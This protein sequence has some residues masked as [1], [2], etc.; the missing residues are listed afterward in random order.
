MKF[1]GERYVPGTSGQI[2]LEHMQRYALCRELARGQRVLDIACGEGY[3]AA[4]LAASAAHTVGIDISPG[5]I[6]HART[7]YRIPKLSFAVGAC[8]AMPLA[9]HSVDVIV[10]FETIEHLSDHE[11]M[12][13]ECRRVLTPEGVL[14]ISSPEREGYRGVKEP[15]PFHLRELTLAEFEQ[16]LRRHFRGVKLWGQRLAVGCFSY[17]LPPHE[18]ASSTFTAITL[19]G[20]RVHDRVGDLPSPEYC[21][22]VCTNRVLDDVHLDSVALEPADDLYAM[23]STTIQGYE[24]TLKRLDQE[25]RTVRTTL[26]SQLA[27]SQSTVAALRPLAEAVERERDQAQ[28]AHDTVER[29]HGELDHVYRSRSWRLTAPMRD[30]RRAAGRLKHR[31][32]LRAEHVLRTAYRKMPVASHYR[33][34]VKSAVF[35]RAGWLMRGTASYQ[36]WE[37]TER[38]AR[39]SSSARRLRHSSRSVGSPDQIRLPSSE[40]PTVSVIIPVYGQIEHTLRC[41]SSIA[42]HAPKTPIEVIVVDDA[43]PDGSAEALARV[44]GLLVVRNDANS[45]FIRSSNR[46]AREARGRF[47]LFLNNDTEVLP[48]WCDELVATFDAVPNAGIAGAKLL[49][50]DGA[51]Q[52]AGGILWRDGS[53]WNYGRFDDPAKP[54]YS[55]RREVDYVSGAALLVPADLFWEV[56]GFDEHYAPAYAED[57][58]LAMK[59][60]ETGRA[61][62]FQPLARIV[63]HEGATS[64]TDLGSGA[65]AHQVAN[66]RKLQVRWQ[67]RLAEQFEPSQSV[68]TA[69]ERGVSRRA[70]ILDHCTPEPDKDAGSITA[71]GIMRILQSLGCKITFVPEDNYLYL[72][73]Y[74]AD[75]QRLGI[76]CLYAPFVTSVEHYLE[77]YG[78]AFDLVLVFRFTAA[79][80]NLETVRRL[81]P[82]AKVILHTSDLH[83]LRE[84]R[85]AALRD[86]TGMQQRAARTKRAEL[87]IV[88][89]VDCT[90]VH[91]LFERD[92]LAQELPG[93][94]VAVFGWAIDVP[95]TSVP[96]EARRDVAFIGGYQHPPNVDAA[97][98]FATDILPLVRQHIPDL[99]FHIVGSNPTTTLRAL[100]S[101]HVNVTGFVEDLGTL[102]DSLVLSVAPLRYGAG[103][104]GKI[105]TSLSYGVPCVATPLGAEGMGLEHGRNVLV[106]STPQEFANEV[107]RLYR[108]QALWQ[109]LST[110]GLQFV[111]EHYSFD[112]AVGLFADILTSIGLPSAADSAKAP[113]AQRDGLEIVVLTDAAAD[114]AYRASSRRRFDERLAIETALVPKI[115]APF[116]VDGFCVG[117]QQPQAFATTFDFAFRGDGGRSTPNWREHLVCACGL[118]ARTRAAI[119]LLTLRLRPARDARIYLMEQQSGLYAWLKHRFPN[120]V[121]SE[122]LGDRASLGSTWQGIRNEDATRLTFADRAFDY[123]LSF[124]VFEHVPDYQRAFNEAW[125]CLAD[126]GTLL[127][128]APFDRGS[129]Q[130]IERARLTAGGEIEHLLPPEFHGDPINPEGG[131]LCFQHFGWDIIDRLKSAG[132]A[133]ARAFFLWSR[134]LGY[135]GGEQVLFTASK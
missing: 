6:A 40:A 31:A 28:R 104:K 91:S 122:Y 9:A 48:N 81:A 1:T 53:A 23:L 115:E 103:I 42:T 44:E 45:G 128:T 11:A 27:E 110:N 135:L 120:L 50:P 75:L 127:F 82:N 51:L 8:E 54:E 73:R 10:S 12:L 52:E 79:S 124:D 72:D 66:A 4:L 7:R 24:G 13:R 16:L 84:E 19:S 39:G 78:A 118:N 130:T 30:A 132:F 15:N 131:I 29:L 77:Q 94:R 49:Y 89:R 41:L 105:G 112:G 47:L 2:K 85:E 62:I 22:A 20:D 95:G 86:D 117:C 33:W 114:R 92:L 100:Q 93:A 101:E 111:R 25:L 90:I 119:H 65:K 60:R 83:F 133:D 80:R 35:R 123:I 36:H 43:S 59:V 71:L 26:E 96:F 57:S 34:R 69:R 106:A 18:S 37:N 64:G 102:L 109:S 76:E 87:D 17:Q 3:G 129:D 67:R 113:R 70:L 74:T 126:G 116:H 108:N 21:L 38:R 56:G 46:G 88:R 99:R 32:A 63:H 121:G 5:V 68:F 134:R 107:V 98:Y 14:I 58:D 125:R 61:V 97:H 55:Y